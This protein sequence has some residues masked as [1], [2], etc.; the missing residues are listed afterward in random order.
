MKHIIIYLLLSAPF[1]ANAQY[2]KSNKDTNVI[3]RF[4]EKSKKKKKTAEDNVIKIAPLG[5][6]TGSFPVYYERVVSDFFTVQLG[7][8]LTNRNYLR[9]SI[10]SVGQVDGDGFNNIV[11][12]WGDGNSAS[13]IYDQADDAFDFSHRTAAFGYM[14]SIQPRLYF[15]SEAPEGAYLGL[16]YE[17]SRYAFKIPGMVENSFSSSYIHKGAT[18]NE[19]ENLSDLMVYFGYHD[20]YDR[21]SVDYTTGMGIRNVKGTKYAFGTDGSFPSTNAPIEGF[22]NYKQTN[23]NFTIGIRVGYHF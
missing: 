18:K 20:L 1:I 5:F 17:Y 12:P 14:F 22:A 4:E 9:N 23:F 15:D 11:Y 19:H 6:I 2:V 8:G 21:L 16:A 7:A 13:T 10:Q 3:V